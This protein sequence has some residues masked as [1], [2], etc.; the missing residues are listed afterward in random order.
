MRFCLM[1]IADESWSRDLLD[2]WRAIAAVD[3]VGR[4]RLVED[5]EEADRV[6]IVD[7]QQHPRDP[8]LRQFRNH[9]LAQSFR[10]KLLVYDERDRPVYTYSGVYVSGRRQQGSGRAVIGGMYSTMDIPE[11][12]TTSSPDL[13]WSFIGA[14]THPVR[15]RILNLSECASFLR[16]TTG[17]ST[18]EKDDSCAQD[19]L[20]RD[21]YWSILS[22][23]QFVVCPRGHGASSFRLYEALAAGSVP[24]V[25]SDDWL[26]P[27][28][29]DWDACTVR[30]AERN[31]EHLPAILAGR[32]SDW[33]DLAA[34]ANAAW[35]QNFSRPRFWDYVAESLAR[36]VPGRQ[37]RP[38]LLSHRDVLRLR[39]AH[40]T[41]PLRRPAS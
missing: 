36:L 16:D 19:R 8:L 23:S 3:E 24:V 30:I 6:L 17:L 5:P 35:R 14:R 28:G 22:R 32:R 11:N 34:A 18:A 13:L 20:P 33:P 27:P 31:V 7:L 26:P 40:V 2:N 39:A 41:A 15:R 25:V 37:V 1:S 10:H 9:S 38:W 21:Q 4:H 29:I 12:P